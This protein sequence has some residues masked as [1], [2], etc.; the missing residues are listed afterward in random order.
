MLNFLTVVG[1]LLASLQDFVLSPIAKKPA[2]SRLLGFL[3]AVTVALIFV[4]LIPAAIFYAIEGWTYGE[5]IYYCF[6]SLTTVGFGDFVPSQSTASRANSTVNLRGLYKL[7]ISCWL[8][9][10]LAL[11]ALIISDVQK[12]L[13]TSG[14]KLRGCMHSW[15]SKRRGSFTVAE[16]EPVQAEE[17]VVPAVE[18]QE[19]V[20]E[21]RVKA[22]EH[23][24]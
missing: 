22:I 17:P 23:E 1:E 19:T 16:K 18:E 15:W 10:G 20:E 2:L 12:L 9:I 24:L 4:I 14:Q 8:V 13:E 6:V 5:G 11:V 7:C 21:E 3:S